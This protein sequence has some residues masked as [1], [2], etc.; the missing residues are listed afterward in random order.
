MFLEEKENVKWEHVV[1]HF[2]LLHCDKKK[3]KK[4][5]YVD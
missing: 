1:K 2:Q 3:K 5:T 4:V